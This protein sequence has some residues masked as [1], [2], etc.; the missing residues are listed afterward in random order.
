[1][2]IQRLVIGVDNMFDFF[3]STSPHELY[4]KPK[5]KYKKDEWLWVN[6]YANV[7][8]LLKVESRKFSNSEQCWLY[9]GFLTNGSGHCLAFSE[10]LDIRKPTQEEIKWG[11]GVLK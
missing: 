11:E 10:R 3:H 6:D 9:T 7:P 4:V 8:H 2:V 5:P 1:M